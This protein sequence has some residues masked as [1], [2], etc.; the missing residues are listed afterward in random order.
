[1]RISVV[2]SVLLHSF[3]LFFTIVSLPLF[4]NNELEMPPIIQVELIEI[5]EKTN[6]PQISKKKEDKKPEKENK[7]EE[8]K[9]NQ[10]IQK[11]KEE[12]SNE[13]VKD[14]STEEKIETKKIEE[15]MIQNMP[16]KKPEIKK[17][18]KF[19]PLKLAELIDKQK[20]TKQTNPED[21]VEKDYDCLLYTSDAA[22]RH[23]V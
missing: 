19:D 17:K 22:T 2:G 13:K 14:P 3:I 21:I 10:P 16:V 12:K 8:Q 4:N 5:A 7:K 23:T 6:V 20:D 9:L 1:M 15:N 11:P 18:D